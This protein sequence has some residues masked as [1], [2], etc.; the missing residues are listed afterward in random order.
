MA[1][2]LMTQTY[3][4][5]LKLKWG[6]QKLKWLIFD[7]CTNANRLRYTWTDPLC[8][9]F[10]IAMTYCPP[11]RVTIHLCECDELSTIAFMLIQ[12]H[13]QE[14]N[15]RPSSINQPIPRLAS[16]DTSI[17]H[18]NHNKP[19]NNQYLIWWLSCITVVFIPLSLI[20]NQPGINKR[21]AL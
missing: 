18:T 4:R 14:F 15:M 2:V 9:F 11:Q 13:N 3:N 10:R 19:I 5:L 8:F 7:C 12:L 21:R 6:L 1:F 20:H 16:F 17:W